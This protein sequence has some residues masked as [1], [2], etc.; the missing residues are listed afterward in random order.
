[1]VYVQFVQENC[2]DTNFILMKRYYFAPKAPK[3]HDSTANFFEKPGRFYFAF[4]HA[5]Y[6]EMPLF[7]ALSNF[8][9]LGYIMQVIVVRGLTEHFISLIYSGRLY[10]IIF[11]INDIQSS[12]DCFCL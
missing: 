11:L 3:R 4:K 10:V 8:K 12:M 2:S 9:V 5:I 7:A 1:M 6:T